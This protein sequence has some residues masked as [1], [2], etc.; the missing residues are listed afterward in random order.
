MRCDA[1]H[2]TIAL[3]LCSLCVGTDLSM[4]DTASRMTDGKAPAPARVERPSH[5]LTA[6]LKALSNVP[7]P[8]VQMIDEYARRVSAAALL[9]ALWHDMARATNTALDDRQPPE[10]GSTAVMVAGPRHVK[11]WTAVVPFHPAEN[12]CAWCWG[13]GQGQR[14]GIGGNRGTGR[15]LRARRTEWSRPRC[16]LS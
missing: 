3:A 1:A 16:G 14:I 5:R 4:G 12:S 15:S 11:P 7:K 8:V 10:W 2:L 6:L 9:H 13:S